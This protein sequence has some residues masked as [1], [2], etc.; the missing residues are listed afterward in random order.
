MALST[1]LLLLLTHP[2]EFRT[3]VQ[4][5]LWHEQKRDITAKEE[6]PT[7]G[8]D[9]PS[10][11]RCW[12]FLDLTSRTFAAV[13]K[14][15]EGDMARVVCLFYL[16]LRGLDTV[17][18]DMTLPMSLKDPM[19]RNFYKHS[20]EPGFCFTGSG[21]DEKDRQLLVEY[22]V[23]VE[24]LQL[25]P[26]AYRSAILSIA[27]KM[28]A[29]MADFAA[30]AASEKTPANIET[31]ADYDLYCHYVAGLVGEGL[32]LLFS[33]SG[34]ESPHL[35]A[36]LEISN[37][38][39][40]LLQKTNITRD[41]REDVDERRYFWPR[42]IWANPMYGGGFS[43]MEEMCL[44]P[45]GTE[46]A[47][48]VRDRAQWVQSAMVL[49]GLRHATDSLDY[50]RM[51]KNQSIFNFC[52]IPATMAMATLEL[53][54]MNPRMFGQ[55]VKIRKAV[56]A[57]LI[58]RS[59]NPREVSYIFR[60]YARKIH[61][62]ALPHDPNFIRISVACGKIEQWCEHYYPSFV[63]LGGG[64]GTSLSQSID[65]KDARGRTF[66]E[67]QEWDEKRSKELRMEALRASLA[68]G[69][70]LPAQQDSGMREVVGYIVL[71]VLLF[72]GTGAGLVFMLMRYTD[73]DY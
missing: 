29:G 66:L 2:L 58:M 73:G 7:S 36:Q 37:S 28:G 38:M 11:R 16:V 31:I 9:R 22:N 72:V 8:Y 6:H 17:E 20:V 46:S 68:A 41:F 4:Y 13:V 35:G 25:L 40:L 39:G 33:A 51:L 42:E 56:A 34:K 24:E 47:P 5:K 48:G 57:S 60:E 43:A 55:N 44:P 3:L 30:R 15:L 64:S 63:I 45:K 52:A 69:N 53:C 62:R 19:L 26:E 18:D 61:A 27:A 65:R 49:D 70:R 71:A 12:D 54:F 21:P 59:T 14:G 10:M 67:Y 23:V 32:S 1:W 50:L